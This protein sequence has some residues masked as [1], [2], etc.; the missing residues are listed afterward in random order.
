MRISCPSKTF[1]VGEYAVIGGGPA[2]LAT[3]PPY[4]VLDNARFIDPYRG[5]GGFGASGA[6]LV[7]ASKKAGYSDPWQVWEKYRQS[8]FYGSGADV[9]AQWMGGITFF[10]AEQ[11]KIEK[12]TWPF[13]N[14]LIALIHTGVKIQTHKHLQTL[15]HQENNFNTLKTITLKAYDSLKA[16]NQEDFLKTIRDYAI[17][18]NQLELVCDNTEIIL[19]KMKN[20]SD[21]LAAK[22][23]GAL[24]ADVI[25]AVIE[26]SQKKNFLD[27][28][29]KE[30]LN[31]VFCDNQFA[32]GVR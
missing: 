21:I 16:Q 28:A 6:R 17:A 20:C 32:G 3:T 12:I 18:L 15:I 22:G 9:V 26:K 2:L 13:E 24:G 30:K 8:G 23:C 31:I 29:G 4:F 5:A 25:L 14:L 27:W 10:Y 1:L 11:Q 7:L 19:D